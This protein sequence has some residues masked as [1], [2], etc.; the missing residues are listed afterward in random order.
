[1]RSNRSARALAIVGLATIGCQ[2]APYL[3]KDGAATATLT[4]GAG[5]AEA[6]E[7]SDQHSL[8]PQERHFLHPSS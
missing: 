1:M 5:H 4:G 8:Y 6:A 3:V 7:Q 2:P